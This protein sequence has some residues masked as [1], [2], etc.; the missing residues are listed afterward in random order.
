[1]LGLD[2]WRDIWAL[3]WRC[4]TRCYRL[5]SKPYVDEYSYDDEYDQDN[6]DDYDPYERRHFYRK[7]RENNAILESTEST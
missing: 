6:R 3:S 7:N 2:Y 5:G 1:M 4:N